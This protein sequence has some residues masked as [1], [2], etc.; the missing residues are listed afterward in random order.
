M[1]LGVKCCSFIFLREK[2]SRAAVYPMGYTP[3]FLAPYSS[4]SHSAWRDRWPLGD[5][6]DSAPPV[7]IW[8]ARDVRNC[9]SEGEGLRGVFTRE[10]GGREMY[11]WVRVRIK[12]GGCAGLAAPPFRVLAAFCASQTRRSVLRLNSQD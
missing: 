4:G 5:S 3:T 8:R 1:I 7:G 6:A 2:L 11:G 9:C 12:K 10:Y